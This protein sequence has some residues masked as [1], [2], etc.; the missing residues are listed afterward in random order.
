MT[1]RMNIWRIPMLPE[2][3]LHFK[4]VLAVVLLPKVASVVGLLAIF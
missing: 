3:M 1:T 4:W 2:M